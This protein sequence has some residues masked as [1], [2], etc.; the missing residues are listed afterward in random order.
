MTHPIVVAHRDLQGVL[1][2][3]RYVLSILRLKQV[4]VG[5]H[6]SLLLEALDQILAA[7]RWLV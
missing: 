5:A 6:L 7:D 4:E 1:I 3:N 2:V